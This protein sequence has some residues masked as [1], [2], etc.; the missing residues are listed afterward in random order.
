M[1]AAAGCATRA[2]GPCTGCV[3]LQGSRD[4]PCALLIAR[5]KQQFELI[6]AAAGCAMRAAGRCTGCAPLQGSRCC[7]WAAR[8]RSSALTRC[9]SCQVSTVS[10]RERQFRLTLRVSIPLHVERV[11]SISR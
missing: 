5:R 11:N 1:C 2:A 3:P 10:C 9:S 6:C 7:T 8:R 4:M